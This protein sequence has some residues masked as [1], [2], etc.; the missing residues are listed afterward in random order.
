ML[1]CLMTRISIA[2]LLLCLSSAGAA[3]LPEP[4]P[5]P[6][7]VAAARAFVA[8]LPIEQHFVA[9]CGMV[10]SMTAPVFDFWSGAEEISERPNAEAVRYHGLLAIRAEVERL[11]PEAAASIRERLALDYAARLSPEA[12][13]ALRIFYST[14]SGPHFASVHV[15][16]SLRISGHVRQALL[17]RLAP[18][19]PAIT[20]QAVE[21]ARRGGQL[22]PLAICMPYE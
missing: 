11:L 18:R 21:R 22:P 4:P 13:D 19:F 12:I 5:S 17:D 16:D 2:F 15:E 6:A 14:G 9:S 3:R 10:E 1:Q 8:R 7:A 20:A